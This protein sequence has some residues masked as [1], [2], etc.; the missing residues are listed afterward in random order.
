MGIKKTDKGW[1]VD[2]R[3]NGSE[4]KRY[5]KTL[6]TKIDALRWEAWIRN[7]HT[8]SKEWEPEKKE[9]RK[10]NDLIE[11]WHSCHGINLKDNHRRLLSLQRICKAL[12]NPYINDFTA[13][14]WL[15]Y[16][17]HRLEVDQV[18]KSTVN[19][20]QTI[21]K[22]VFKELIRIDDLKIDPMQKIRKLKEDET[23][24]SFLNPEQ[25][26]ELLDTLKKTHYDSYCISLVCLSTGAR[27]S[28][29]ETLEG[30]QLLER[31]KD[32]LITYTETKNKKNR[33]IPISK[34]IVRKFRR[35]EGRLFEHSLYR[36]RRVCRHKL[37]FKLPEQQMTHILRH[38]F[39]SYF[40]M[41]GGNILVLQKILGHQSLEM[42]LRYSHLAPEHLEEAIMYNPIGQK[43]DTETKDNKIKNSKHMI[44]IKN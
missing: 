18:K 44:V 36:Y 16:R 8:Q 4:G 38:K 22:A 12:K 15:N 43:M 42:T 41:N 1:L 3:P 29:A 24:L 7:Q 14:D 32:Y 28:E 2:I 27:W 9:S 35:K 17:K 31:D 19:Y 39:A 26:T 5:R 13:K 40:M 20:E 6:P 37:I 10:L 34:N 23:E 11:L 30:H 33:S 25:Q 21:L